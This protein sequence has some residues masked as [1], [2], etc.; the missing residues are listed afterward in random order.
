MPS[1]RSTAPTTGRT[2]STRQPTRRFDSSPK[3][4]L[5]YS[6]GTSQAR[7]PGGASRSSW[8]G[9]RDRGQRRNRRQVRRRLDQALVRGHRLGV[10]IG[11][12]QVYR[13][14]LNRCGG[15]I[16]I[17]PTVRRNLVTGTRLPAALRGKPGRLVPAF[18]AG[19]LGKA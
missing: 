11:G 9:R 7:P 5:A 16:R 17:E 14:G 8:L 18:G 10:Q 13:F 19:E 12:S 15:Q 6:D 2:W 3:R 1:T 4:P